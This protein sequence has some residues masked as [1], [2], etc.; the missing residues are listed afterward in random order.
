MKYGVWLDRAH[1]SRKLRRWGFSYQRPAVRAVERNEDDIATWVR[2]QGE[3]LGKKG[4]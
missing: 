4:R 2:V 1:L 3:A